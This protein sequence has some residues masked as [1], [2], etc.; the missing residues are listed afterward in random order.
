MVAGS[1]LCSIK[2]VLERALQG[3]GLS[4]LRTLC[5]GH[6]PRGIPYSVRTAV[7]AQDWQKHP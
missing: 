5:F 6:L 1:P 7:Y 2:P 4:I 3:V